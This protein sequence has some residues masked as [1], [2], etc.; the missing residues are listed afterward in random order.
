MMHEMVVHEGKK[1]SE[2]NI[3]QT[4]EE[5]KMLA[6]NSSLKVS[7]VDNKMNDT[8]K[9]NNEEKKEHFENASS[10]ELAK[11]DWKLFRPEEFN[12]KEEEI[13]NSEYPKL[14]YKRKSILTKI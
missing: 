3:K 6:Q 12:L 4:L 9:L 7:K 8:T 5:L 14:A 10:Q 11:N 2:I 1:L 13:R